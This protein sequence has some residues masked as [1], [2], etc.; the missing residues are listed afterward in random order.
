[1]MFF[2]GFISGVGAMVLAL[3]ALEFARWLDG[4][5]EEEWF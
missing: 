4:Q 2:L 1:M 5:G 3:G